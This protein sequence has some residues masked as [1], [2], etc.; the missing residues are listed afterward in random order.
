MAKAIRRDAWLPIQV[1]N[2]RG[3]PGFSVAFLLPF[4]V[5]SR[6]D[7]VAGTVTMVAPPNQRLKLAARLD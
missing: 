6:R 5:G 1:A 4:S 2:T 7:N 3:F